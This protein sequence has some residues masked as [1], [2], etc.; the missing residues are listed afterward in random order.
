MSASHTYFGLRR[1][2]RKTAAIASW[3]DRPG[4]ASIAVRLELRLPCRFEGKLHER[5]LSSLPHDGNSQWPPFAWF[6]W[7]RKPDPTN[8]LGF[9]PF[10]VGRLKTFYQG[11]S[12]LRRDGLDAVNPRCLFALVILGHPSYCQ[13]PSGFRFQQQFLQFLYFSC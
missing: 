8:G 7:L 1:I 6:P 11:Q 13:E 10:P 5:L 12:C 4:R 3:H 9:A 2:A